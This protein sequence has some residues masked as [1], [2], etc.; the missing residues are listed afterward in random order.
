M[1]DSVAFTLVDPQTK[2]QLQGKL[3]VSQG[4][5]LVAFD[6]YG[7]CSAMTGHGEPLMVELYNGSLV[8]RVWNDINSEKPVRVS[9]DGAREELYEGDD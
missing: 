5:L 7:E 2:E 6:G 1:I 3:R 8:V 4:M 9:L